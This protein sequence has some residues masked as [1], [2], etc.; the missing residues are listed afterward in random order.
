MPDPVIDPVLPP[1]HPRALELI[2]QLRWRAARAKD[3]WGRPQVPHEYTVR[4]HDDPWAEA[5][6]IELWRYVRASPVHERWRKNPPK[7]YLYP[8][9]GFK[10]WTMTGNPDGEIINRMP[11]ADDQE[12]RPA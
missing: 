3:R 5:Q 8:G 7:P 9:D 6:W 12:S 1:P 11:I 4:N 2:A 10:Y